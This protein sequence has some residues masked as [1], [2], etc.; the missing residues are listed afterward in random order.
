VDA[1]MRAGGWSS[2]AMYKRYL[3]MNEDD[4]ANAFG[5]ARIDKRINKKSAKK[6]ATPRK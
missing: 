6:G 2:L 1:V 4:V 5:T 3:D